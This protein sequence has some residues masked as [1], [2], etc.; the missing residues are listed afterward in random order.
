MYILYGAVQFTSYTAISKMLTLFQKDSKQFNF[1]PAVHSLVVGTGAGIT[2]T[3]VTYPF[4]L[5][6]TR[7]AANNKREIL[8]MMKTINS[9]YKND[10][11]LGFFIGIRPAVLS[12]ASNTGLMFW[13]YEL[14]REFTSNYTEV[15]F[16]EGICGF[17][18]GATAKGITF[19]LDTLR[20][21]IQV[22]TLDHSS[23]LFSLCKQIIVREGLF[24][25]YKGFGISVFKT[26]PT[27]AMSIFIYEYTIS[28]IRK[29]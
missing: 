12:V 25:L 15:P 16:I 6:R 7:L 22:K 13:A 10:G 19:P 9:I 11:M 3:A 20:K 21:R 18:A 8:S 2:S 24:G 23:S 26:A 27:S 29:S 17:F 4:D 14:A 5:L 1:S 28:I